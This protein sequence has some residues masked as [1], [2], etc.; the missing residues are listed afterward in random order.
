MSGSLR[1]ANVVAGLLTENTKPMLAQAVR[2]L[3]SIRWFG[4]ELAAAR[5]V[6]CGVGEL[7]AN[8]RRTLESYG[9]EVRT[10]SRFHPANPTAN[11]LQLFDELL[12]A[13][14]E[15]L[16][17]LDCD[18]LVV[19]DPLP[20][21]TGD[22]FQAKIAPTPTVSDDVFERLFAH[23][24]LRKPPRA[25]VTP[26][27]GTPT[28]PYFN[29]GV[30]AVPTS[31]AQLLVPAWRRFNLALA[32]QPELVAPCQRH[33]HQAALA[34]AL[35]ETGI[36]CVELPSAMNYQLNATHVPAP[37][38]YAELDPV[39]LHYHHLATDDGF[40]L[41]TP[42]PGAQRRIDEFH[43][44]MRAEGFAPHAT[45]PAKAAESRPIVVLGMHRSGTS[46]LAQVIEALGAYAGRPD[47]LAPPDM[48]NPTGYWEHKAVVQLDT[49]I[50]DE[51]DASWTDIAHA[52]VSRLAPSRRAELV[53]RAKEA[54]RPL[55][56]RGPFVVKDPRMA[57]LFPLW[58]EALRDPVVVI[59]WREPA[60]VARSIAK[61]DNRPLLASLALWEHYT[62]TL[63]RDSEGAPRLVVSYEELLADPIRVARDLHAQLTALGVHGL[64][65]PS[66]AR[67]RQI[68]HADFNRSGRDAGDAD[69]LLDSEQRALVASLRD[70][71]AIRSSV[72]PTSP[73]TLALLAHFQAEEDREIEFRRRIG[74]LDS[75]LHAVFASR[76][77][78][79][80]HSLTGVL[81]R[82]RRERAVTAE[83]RLRLMKD[84]GGTGR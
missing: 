33:M 48:F 83:E 63:L 5:V 39:I 28:I 12:D 51:L 25:H 7:E 59:A 81:R 37:P 35:A 84:G 44:R 42:Y 38:G 71:S 6:V 74:N 22:R 18:T 40:L 49:A 47:E 76:S 31:M 32:E 13:P 65:V 58:R 75:L 64:Q 45:E 8:A 14:E 66:D 27:D 67:M 80:G 55:E 68:V 77:W 79:L 24:D 36:P 69:A 26:F 11:R 50:L 29:S 3:R 23:F 60:A 9:A 15:L 41:P 54:I 62:R 4:G 20:L 70:G 43:E 30:I 78:R 2:L 17:V 52:D 16:L 1:A 19:Q 82:L 72:A 34:L 53:E 57:L 21:L 61:R 56:G 10:V 46:L 73:R